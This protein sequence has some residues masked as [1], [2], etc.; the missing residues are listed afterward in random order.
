MKSY[1][2]ETY[3]RRIVASRR[4]ELSLTQTELAKRLGYPNANFVSQLESGKSKVPLNK[5]DEFAAALEI[6]KKW[7]AER[8]LEAR[9]PRLASVLLR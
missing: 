6:D 9:Y 7:F 1:R 8:L 4:R 5:V 2:H 3:P